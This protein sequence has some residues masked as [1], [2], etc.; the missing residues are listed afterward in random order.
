MVYDLR[1]TFICQNEREEN[2]MIT[3]KEVTQHMHDEKNIGSRRYKK[4]YKYL[5]KFS[6]DE[7]DFL[8]VECKKRISTYTKPLNWNF[9]A[10]II[11][12]LALMGAMVPE[13]IKS[14]SNGYQDIFCRFILIII[15]ILFMLGIMILYENYRNR[16][17][18]ESTEL[19]EIINKIKRKE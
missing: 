2:I 11:S 7:L 5:K 12:L 4:L 14:F 10:I 6:H 19:L 18:N 13:E 3:V 16:E 9:I 15:F 17:Y 1:V 8:E